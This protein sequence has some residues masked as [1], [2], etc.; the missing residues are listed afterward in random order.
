MVVWDAE[1]VQGYFPFVESAITTG[2]ARASCVRR[3]SEIISAKGGFGGLCTGYE[4]VDVIARRPRGD[5]ARTISP[6]P[7]SAAAIKAVPS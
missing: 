2:M 3:S 6:W 4:I 5:Q 1:P 7:N